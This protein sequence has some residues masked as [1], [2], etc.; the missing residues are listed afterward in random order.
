M[1]KNG[2]KQCLR[3][4]RQGD[5][6]RFGDLIPVCSVIYLYLISFQKGFEVADLAIDWICGA[7]EKEETAMTFNKHL[8]RNELVY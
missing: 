5:L 3:V 2:K 1:H 6:V 7:S 4:V 8:L